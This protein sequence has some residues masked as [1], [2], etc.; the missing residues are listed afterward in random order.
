[1]ARRKV[2]SASSGPFTVYER[3]N[4]ETGIVEGYE[5]EGPGCGFICSSLKEAADLVEQMI[6]DLPPPEGDYDPPTP[7]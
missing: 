7:F 4:D 6:R 1:M 5:V 2:H 3:R